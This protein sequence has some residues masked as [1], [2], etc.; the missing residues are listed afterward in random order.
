MRI[1]DTPVHA[2]IREALSNCLIHTQLDESGSI[3]VE[4]KKTILN[5]QIQEI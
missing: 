4:K 5:L 1:D 2:C 3:V